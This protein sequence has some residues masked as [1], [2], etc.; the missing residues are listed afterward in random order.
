MQGHDRQGRGLQGG[1]NNGPGGWQGGPNWRGG[2]G[3]QGSDWHW[4]DNNGW[5]RDHDR[6][7]RPNYGAFAGFDR[8][9]F[10]LRRHHFDRVDGQ[11]YWFH[12]RYVV[13]TFDRSGRVVFVEVNPYTGAFIGVV[14]FRD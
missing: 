1:P 4:Q 3:P 6:Y 5:H 13:R 12:G 11:P 9:F 14:Q 8:I 7:W 10:D 2:S